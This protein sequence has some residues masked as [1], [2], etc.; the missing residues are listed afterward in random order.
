MCHPRLWGQDAAVGPAVEWGACVLTEQVEVA[1][2]T[3][4]VCRHRCGWEGP[5]TL[6]LHPHWTSGVTAWRQ[7]WGSEVPG[8]GGVW[9]RVCGSSGVHPGP[10]E[11]GR[12]DTHTQEDSGGDLT[13]A[14]PVGYP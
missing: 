13:F 3:L 12:G 8:G 5:I 14:F 9:L 6:I 4:E 2:Q 10:R 1:M 7:R 11:D